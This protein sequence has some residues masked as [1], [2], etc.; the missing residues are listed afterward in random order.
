MLLLETPEELGAMN[1]EGY[2]SRKRG[3]STG[4]T[5]KDRDCL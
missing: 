3:T 1:V 2:L 4:L 5:D